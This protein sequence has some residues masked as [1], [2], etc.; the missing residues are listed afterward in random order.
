M[1]QIVVP[2]TPP[3]IILSAIDRLVAVNANGGVSPLASHIILFGENAGHNMGDL[4][5]TIVLGAFAFDAGITDPAYAGSIIMGINAASGALNLNSGQPFS[6][7][8]IGRN[9]LMNAGGGASANVLIGDGVMELGVGGGGSSYSAN[10]VLGAQA[11][12]AVLFQNG[13]PFNANVILG[14]QAAK[15][16]GVATSLVNTVIIGN[17]AASNFANGIDG[18]IVIGAGAATNLSGANNIIMGTNAASVNG[19]T[20]SNN[21]IIGGGS[22]MRA[23]SFNSCFGT[24]TGIL[25]GSNNVLLGARIGAIQAASDCVIIGNQAGVFSGLTDIGAQFL[26]EQQ[27]ASIVY[28]QF[29]GA[30]GGSIVLGNSV[31]AN[32]TLPGTNIVQLMNG[33]AT[34]NPVGGGMLYGVAGELRWRNPAGQDTLLTPGAGFTV[35]TLPAGLPF[36]FAGARTYVTNALAP[37]FG[38][39]VAG[40]GAVTIPVFF[41]GAAWIVG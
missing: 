33:T 3:S 1:G 19:T 8:V 22:T 23:G 10:V 37:A 27:G 35:A 13:S 30:S 7:V 6:D 4:D 16:N 26:I 9:A 15:G 14:F 34:G 5:G 20:G 39:A 28:G 25:D 38:A 24:A 32:R 36:A 31:A 21:C 29:F 11:A 17:G 41:N 12:Q 2:S 40:G 18:S